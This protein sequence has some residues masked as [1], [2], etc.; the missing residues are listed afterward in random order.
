MRKDV[1][2]IG[3]GAA[4]L[5]CAV[6]AGKRGKSV[7][8]LDYGNVPGRKIL[9][10]GG[11]RCNFTNLF[12]DGESYISENPHFCKSAQ[13][14]FGPYDFIAMLER[15]G[16]GYHE[17]KSGQLF[18]DGPAGSITEM[19]LEECRTAGVEIL[20]GRRVTAVEKGDV[21]RVG[22]EQ[23]VVEGGALVTATGG[24]SMPKIGATR[25]GYEIAVKFGHRVTPLH[26]ALTPFR[27]AEAEA[28]AFEGLGGIS[29][30]AEVSCGRV[31]FRE[32]LL[33]TH[34]G[35]SGPVILQISS[36]WNDGEPVTVDFLPGMNIL[37]ELMENRASGKR[38]DTFLDRFLP[39]RFAKRWCALRGIAK[40]MNGFSDKEF[41]RV[42]RDLHGFTFTP[43]EV[44]G[45]EKA[46]VTRGGIDTRNISSKTME[47]RLVPGLYFVGE[48]LDVTG[49]LGGFN[50]QWA[51]SSGAA[52][53]RSV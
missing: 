10:S 25:F 1:V 47:S 46:E 16:I 2:I 11:G 24:L 21:F 27:F 36:H 52:A 7:V 5:M 50:L 9:V 20:T 26:P 33:F 18:C 32:S 37:K 22:G 49:Y 4:G 43:A 23:G 28:G 14:R 34:R 13:A 41:E 51:W 45:Y 53:G 48:V 42:A 19:L 29:L 39:G 44:E 30:D 31:R 15:Y 12:T 38:L 17:K 8:V 3:A 40:P 6:E 35:L